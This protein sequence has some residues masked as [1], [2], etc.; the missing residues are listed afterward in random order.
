METVE[1]LRETAQ[2]H[3]LQIDWAKVDHTC[4]Q[5]QQAKTAGRTAEAVREFCRAV[6]Q[7]MQ[8]LRTH[9]KKKASDSSVLG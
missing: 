7:L 2:E 5:A 6:S 4:E 3:Q 1:K 9:H 8:E